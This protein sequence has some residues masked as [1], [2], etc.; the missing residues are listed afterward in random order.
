M[1]NSHIFVVFNAA[2][3]EEGDGSNHFPPP[4]QQIKGQKTGKD[5][6]E[7]LRGNVECKLLCGGVAAG[8]LLCGG[9]ETGA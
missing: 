3:K 5:N 8:A 1:G 2:K 6:S 4:L 7:L 9:D